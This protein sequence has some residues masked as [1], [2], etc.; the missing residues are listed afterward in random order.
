MRRNFGG[1]SL[2]SGFHRLAIGLLFLLGARGGGR[3]CRLLNPARGGEGQHCKQT[4]QECGREVA[5][6][7]ICFHYFHWL[8]RG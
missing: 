7:K 1:N 4:N 6:E 8:I 2:V 5:T 3:C